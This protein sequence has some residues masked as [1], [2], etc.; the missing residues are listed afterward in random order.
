MPFVPLDPNERSE[1]DVC[2]S[3]EHNPPNMMVL[4]QPMK[5]VCPACGASQIVY[6][7][8]YGVTWEAKHEFHTEPSWYMSA[9]MVGMGD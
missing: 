4:N 2:R 3:L 5:W 6:P 8:N 1:Y 9:R 7:S